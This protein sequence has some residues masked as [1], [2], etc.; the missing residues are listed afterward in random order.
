MNVLRFSLRISFAARPGNSRALPRWYLR[1]G[2]RRAG[3]CCFRRQSD[4]HGQGNRC[5]PQATTDANRVYSVTRLTPGL[6]TVTVEKPGF[7]QGVLDNLQVVADQMNPANQTL[8]G[9]DRTSR[10]SVRYL[11]AGNQLQRVPRSP[12]YRRGRNSQQVVWPARHE[13]PW[14]AR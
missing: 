14:R 11:A 10:M 8:S 4:C 5:L 9:L 13:V 3:Q 7:K 1:D 12:V 6:Y 2:D